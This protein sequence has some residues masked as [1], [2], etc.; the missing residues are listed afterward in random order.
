IASIDPI[1]VMEAAINSVRPAAAAKSIHIA[2]ELDP[3]CGVITADGDRLQQVM[4]NLLS[5]AIKFTPAGGHVTLA[6]RRGPGGLT[7]QVADDGAGIEVGFLPY[8]FD[9]FRQ[10]D[11]TT[12]RHH[13]GLGLG[14]AIARHLVEIHGGTIQAE[15]LGEGKGTTLIVCLPLIRSSGKLRAELKQ[16]QKRKEIMEP[17]SPLKGVHVLLV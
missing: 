17:Q 3:A 16:D 4:W 6:M 8:V 15:S 12:T 1:S 11:S 14:L 10:A 5:N 7:I 13:G 2:A 9:R